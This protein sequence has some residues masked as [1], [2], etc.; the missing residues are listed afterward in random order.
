MTKPQDTHATPSTQPTPGGE[1]GEALALRF[2]ETYERLA[3]SFGYETR[4]D[5]KAFDPDS[6][7]GRLMIAVCSELSAALSSSP[8][9]EQAGAVAWQWRHGE[10]DWFTSSERKAWFEDES[11][12]PRFQYRPLYAHPQQQGAVEVA[13]KALEE[14]K[15][16]VRSWPLDDHETCMCG[17][18]VE[19]HNE[20]SGHSPVSQADHAVSMLVESIDE[21]LAALST[22]AKETGQ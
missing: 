14:T 6:P 20:G 8:S 1:R 7:N 16:R 22:S 2:H 13:R 19:G 17:S 11:L 10:S 9:Q 21:A 4:P 3:P 12:N 5:T 18:P 15:E